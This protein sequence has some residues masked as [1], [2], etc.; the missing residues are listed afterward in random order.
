MFQLQNHLDKRYRAMA[1]RFAF[2]A[3][4]PTELADWQQHFRDELSQL[5]GIADR[6]LPIVPSSERLSVSDKGRYYEE[7]H[8]LMLDDV[9]IPMYLLIPKAP[10][11][12]RII[13]AF[14]GHGPGVRLILGNDPDPVTHA[15]NAALDENFAQRFA[16]DGYMVCAIEQRG[17]GERVTRQTDPTKFSNSCRHLAFEYILHGMNLL[18]ERV[19]D[20]IASLNYVLGRA[21][22]VTDFVGCT[23]HSGGAATALFLSA[24]D[25]RL[26]TSVISGYFCSYKHSILGMPHCECNYVPNLLTLGD[27]GEITALIAPRRLCIL[28]GRQD[29]IFPLSGVSEPYQ[30]LQRAY[31]VASMLESCTLVFHDGGHRYNYPVSYAWMRDKWSSK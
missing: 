11:P 27:I 7:K 30:V 15:A 13:L 23:G 5:L 16:E 17:F 14:H 24:L 25:T 10:P 31:S 2:D 6:P 9:V 12:Y 21:D 28:N 3:H 1:H 4:T 19:R 18:G 26:T 29:T 8:A 20:G 22:V